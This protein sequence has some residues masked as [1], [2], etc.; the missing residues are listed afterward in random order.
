M[1]RRLAPEIRACGFVMSLI[2]VAAAAGG[3]SSAASPDDPGSTARAVAAHDQGRRSIEDAAIAL[4]EAKGL[5][6][7]ATEIRWQDDCGGHFGYRASDHICVTTDDHGVLAH[8]LAH[9][10]VAANLTEEDRRA[11]VNEFDSYS[12]NDPT[13]HHFRRGTEQAANALS[14]YVE[15]RIPDGADRLWGIVDFLLETSPAHSEGCS[16]CGLGSAYA[17]T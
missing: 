4:Y 6:V 9:A 3:A 17:G 15:N 14:R 2:V 8:E 12:W 7:P 11:F 16:L 5:D 13:D 10:W 1:T